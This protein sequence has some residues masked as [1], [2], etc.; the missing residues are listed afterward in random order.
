MNN[1]G[2]L[3]LIWKGKN[4]VQLRNFRKNRIDVQILGKDFNLWRLTYFYGHLERQKRRDSWQ[5]LKEMKSHSNMAWCVVGDF[6]DLMAQAEKRGG[7]R[8]PNYLIQGFRDAVNYGGLSEVPMYATASRGKNLEVHLLGWKKN[9]IGHY[10]QRIGIAGSRETVINEDAPPSDHLA[11][12]LCT[13]ERTPPMRH[14]FR[15]E[16][17]WVLEAECRTLIT[18]SWNL[19]YTLDVQ[20]GIRKCALDLGGLG[21]RKKKKTVL[22]PAR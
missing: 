9:L 15:F 12:I 22:D 11:I 17:A 7:L 18:K 16:N 13:K 1:G 6:N 21:S 3:G 2:G 19:P 8:H 20:E 10:R 4:L 5:L 14:I